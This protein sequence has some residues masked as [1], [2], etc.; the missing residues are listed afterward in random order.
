MRE[1]QTDRQEERECVSVCIFVHVSVPLRSW[2]HT[3]S[4]HSTGIPCELFRLNH[5][6]NPYQFVF[7]CVSQAVLGDIIIIPLLKTTLQ[8]R[9]K[10]ATKMDLWS[11][12]SQD[13]A[14]GMTAAFQETRSE[15][16]NNGKNRGMK[17]EREGVG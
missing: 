9:L 2:K 11:L 6:Q 13:V 7:A 16:G 12:L 14:E 1:R 10:N 3:Y 17:R 5:S 4:N 15:R 8:E